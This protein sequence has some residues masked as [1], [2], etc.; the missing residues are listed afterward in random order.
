MP[1]E[2]PRCH[3]MKVSRQVS[4]GEKKKTYDFSHYIYIIGEKVQYTGEKVCESVSPY[5]LPKIIRFDLLKARFYIIGSRSHIIIN[6][7][8]H[9]RP[10]VG[11]ISNLP[12]HKR[13]IVRRID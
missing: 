3:K 1:L 6:L 10:I 11:R 13:P 5:F 2:E 4:A 9:K 12:L 8:L 7:P